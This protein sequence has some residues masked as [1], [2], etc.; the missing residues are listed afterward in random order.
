LAIEDRI[1]KIDPL[2]YA[3]TRNYYNGA[4]TYLSPYISRGIISTSSIYKHLKSNFKWEESEKLI[5][6][7]AW[8]DYWQNV[9]RAVGSEIFKPIKNPQF[10]VMNHGVPSA[11][12]EANTGIEVVDIAIRHLYTSGYMHN[13]MR[14]YVAS[15]CCNIARCDWLSCAN[16]MYS[17]LFDGDLA[18]NHLNWQWVAGTFSN[19]RYVANQENINT[20][21][22][23]QQKGTFLDIPYES[24][25]NLDVPEVLKSTDSHLPE[26]SLPDIKRP[27]LKNQ[28]T[29]IYTYYNL[30]PYWHKEGKYQRV[31][32]LEPNF[33]KKHPVSSMC[34]SFVFQLAKNIPNVKIFSGS[35]Q[36][37]LELI[38]E[39]NLVFKEH[40][41]QTH[42]KGQQEER[43]WL[44][45]VV[46]YFPSFF[47]FWNQA[48]KEL[49]F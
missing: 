47:K 13:H 44:T 32:L 20:N 38:E 31:L 25:E 49:K 7:L 1:S 18:S 28:P 12:V 4:I 11:V 41:T 39:E 8:R 6:E 2:Q 37:I 17:H 10:K 35:F 27:V 3:K 5:Q 45:S 24:F 21:F 14:M 43:A 29:L 19:K 26:Y 22:G 46:G 16:W 9:W 33:L 30:D 40:P 34:L 15:I 36:E 48:K 42:F 23:S